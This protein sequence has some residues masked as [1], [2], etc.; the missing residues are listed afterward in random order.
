MADPTQEIGYSD[1]RDKLAELYW[2]K[3]D[4]RRILIETGLNPAFVEISDRAINTWSDIIREANDRKLLSPLIRKALGQFPKDE[5]LKRALEVLDAGGII[6]EPISGDTPQIIN[7]LTTPYYFDLEEPI[8]I[9]RKSFRKHNRGPIGLAVDCR[10]SFFFGYFS[11]RLASVRELH[12]PVIPKDDVPIII[13]AETHGITRALNTTVWLCNNEI[14]AGDVIITIAPGATH[15]DY[16]DFWKKLCTHEKVK[17]LNYRLIL[18]FPMKDDECQSEETGLI[19]LGQPVCRIDTAENWLDKILQNFNNRDNE[20]SEL[21]AKTIRYECRF[22]LNQNLDHDEL[23][24]NVAQMWKHIEATM[25]EMEASP[26]LEGVILML[27]ERMKKYEAISSL[28]H[29]N[30]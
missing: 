18:I 9:S 26:A 5:T 11:Q 27:K 10:E 17:S 2:D 7:D 21:W 15:K 19:P 14:T 29:N 24:I 1:L 23:K 30:E 16:I 12:D 4:T 3:A 6:I 13:N 22:D 8:K 25:I 20:L 28:R